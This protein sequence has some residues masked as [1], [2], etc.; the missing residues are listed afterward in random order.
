MHFYV[1]VDREISERAGA[2]D[3]F[4]LVSIEDENGKNYAQHFEQ[5]FH[6]CSLDEVK[7]QLAEHLNTDVNLVSLEEI[8]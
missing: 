8:A 4:Q 5:G 1:Q 7:N 6:Y 3:M 2:A